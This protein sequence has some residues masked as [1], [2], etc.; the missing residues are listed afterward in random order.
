MSS[1]DDDGPG[2]VVALDD[3]ADKDQLL[4]ML[5]ESPNAAR[6]RGDVKSHLAHTA[7]I[8]VLVLINEGES[9][10]PRLTSCSD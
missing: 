1:D 2:D 3:R 6:A 9:C 5:L 10:S 8:R 7:V 4:A